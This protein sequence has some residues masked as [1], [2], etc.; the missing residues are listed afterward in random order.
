MTARNTLKRQIRARMAKTGEAYTAARQ[1]FRVAE[2]SPMSTK[3]FDSPTLLV[4]QQAQPKLWPDWVDQHPWLE[5]FLPKAEAE[6]RNQGYEECDHFCVQLAFLRLGS[7]ADDWFREL[8]V[9]APQWREDIL[10]ALGSNIDKRTFDRYLEFGKRI[11]IARKSEN[12]IEDLPLK[13]IT[14]EAQQMLELAKSEAE[15]DQVPI[16][17]RHFMVPMM[18]L[19]PY[20]EPTLEELRRITGR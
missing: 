12:P 4:A 2:D 16:D 14:W 1:H 3:T 10:V 9:N 15:R 6:A 13:K 20:G 17:E 7:P 11:Q 18:D 19:H 5:A 8:Q